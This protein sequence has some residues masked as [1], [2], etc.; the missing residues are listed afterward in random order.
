[1]GMFDYYRPLPNLKCPGCG[2]EFDTLW[3]GKDGPNALFLWEQG[4]TAPVDQM[5]DVEIRSP[6]TLRSECRLPASFAIFNDGCRCARLVVAYGNC[7]GGKWDQAEVETHENA[8][9]APSESDR[10][11]RMRVAALKRWIEEA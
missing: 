4:S 10:E 7:I 11:F 8:M 6:D 2:Y 1:M 3:Q 5:V 9:P